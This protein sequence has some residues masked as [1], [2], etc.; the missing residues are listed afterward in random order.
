[1]NLIHPT[2]LRRLTAH[3]TTSSIANMSAERGP[4]ESQGASYRLTRAFCFN[5]IRSKFS[6]REKLSTDTF[7][8]QYDP[9]PT[10]FRFDVKFGGEEGGNFGVSLA[11]VSR[12]TTLTS[13]QVNLYDDRNTPLATVGFREVCRFEKTRSRWWSKMHKFDA[14]SDS[15]SSW[16]I[17]IDF[18]YVALPVPAA[19]PSAVDLPNLRLQK[20]FSQ[21]LDSGDQSDVT[22]VV[23]G[24]KL[25]AH[26][27]VL[28]TRCEVFGSMF[29]SGMTETLSKEVEITDI[30]PKAFKE[31]LRFLYTD[32]APKYAEDST[33]EL[34][35]AAD[36]Y[37]VNDLKAMC[38][39]AIS[40]NLN[41]RNV[42]DALLLAEKHNCPTLMTSAK[43]VFGSH[44]KA[45]KSKKAWNKLSESPALLLKLVEHFV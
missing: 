40:S 34:L 23:Q 31:F 37:C 21:L 42:I 9:F 4:G 5:D 18:T 43:A 16:R 6:K 26:K 17:V 45:L 35:A 36:K 28:T 13:V 7:Y 10:D 30:K 2:Y 15:A 20:Q 38:E 12:D 33:M 19:F 24:E 25:K 29:D 11:P 27:L 14:T 8:C 3:G 32:V 22:F 44:A 39:T 1:M 41:G